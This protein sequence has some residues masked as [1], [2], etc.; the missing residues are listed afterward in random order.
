[1]NLPPI[2]I[3]PAR[4]DFEI[5]IPDRISIDYPSDIVINYPGYP[6]SP[7]DIDDYWRPFISNKKSRKV[8]WKKEGF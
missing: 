1:M 7:Q 3:V 5:S 4:D 8:N 6:I 2:T